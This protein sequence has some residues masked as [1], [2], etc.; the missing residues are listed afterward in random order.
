MISKWLHFPSSSVQSLHLNSS[1]QTLVPT[2]RYPCLDLASQCHEEHVS[3][4]LGIQAL[5]QAL[6]YAVLD[7]GRSS[8]RASSDLTSLL[9][10]SRAAHIL[11]DRS[12]IEPH[13]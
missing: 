13:P 4:L 7:F 6:Q 1:C 11:V 3:S 8:G 9:P 10:P 2:P 12:R 5:P